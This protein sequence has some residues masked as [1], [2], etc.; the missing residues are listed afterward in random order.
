[1]TTPRTPTS[2][3]ST[4]M[5]L[6]PALTVFAG[7]ST[8]L[9]FGVAGQWLQD[10]WFPLTHRFW[11]IALDWLGWSPPPGWVDYFTAILFF[12]P[13]AL[14]PMRR[15]GP[16]RD[17]SVAALVLAVVVCWVLARSS[18]SDGFSLFSNVVDAATDGVLWLFYPLGYLC[19]MIVPLLIREALQDLRPDT[20][21]LP[22]RPPPDPTPRWRYH[23]CYAWAGFCLLGLAGFVAFDL[24]QTWQRGLGFDINAVRLEIFKGP[25]PVRTLVAFGLSLTVF[26]VGFGKLKP[27]R[28]PSPLPV[29]KPSKPK[30]EERP[31]RKPPPRVDSE[32]RI[33]MRTY[34]AFGVF[35]F[36]L[37]SWRFGF[38]LSLL[39]TILFGLIVAT[40][41]RAPRRMIQICQTV[42]ILIVGAYAIDIV[43]VLRR[44]AE[45]AATV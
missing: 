2:L 8:L 22:V 17:H 37:G 27:P 19:L 33:M 11:G 34:A 32:Y 31:D 16:G 15:H 36:L 26:Y 21:G 25:H 41:L 40:S 6:P 38:G 13:A 4:L 3:L 42:L 12:L 30:P 1:M 44:W 5:A 24:Y 23:L 20:H 10:F 9:T 7:L 43:D 39:L 28:P 14:W 35:G 45:A 18:L 29:P